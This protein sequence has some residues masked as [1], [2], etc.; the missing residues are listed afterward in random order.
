MAEADMMD[1]VDMSVLTEAGHRSG[2]FAAAEAMTKW[3]TAIFAAATF[4][5]PALDRPAALIVALVT[6][7][8]SPSRNRTGRTTM[9]MLTYRF[10]WQGRHRYFPSAR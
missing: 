7:P 4:T 8:T 6:A 9:R 10:V 1:M 2:Y 3:F 5:V